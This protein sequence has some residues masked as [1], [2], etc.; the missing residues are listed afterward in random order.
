MSKDSIYG[1]SDLKKKN[2]RSKIEVKKQK[3]YHFG[4]M[5]FKKNINHLQKSGG[6][7]SS[8][9]SGKSTSIRRSKQGITPDLNRIKSKS[10]SMK[11]N[12]MKMQPEKKSK[13]TDT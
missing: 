4:H 10:K 6:C 3:N 13:L 11:K 1:L 7:N 2:D 5:N 8:K 9:H 12:K